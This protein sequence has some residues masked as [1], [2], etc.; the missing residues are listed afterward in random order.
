MATKPFLSCLDNSIKTERFISIPLSSEDISKYNNNRVYFNKHDTKFAFHNN[1]YARNDTM[2]FAR[3]NDNTKFIPIFCLNNNNNTKLKEIVRE[4]KLTA[5]ADMNTKN[6]TNNAS[7][8]YECNKI[9]IPTDNNNWYYTDGYKWDSEYNY[10]MPP[11]IFKKLF[12]K[13]V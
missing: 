13:Q 10:N 5:C 6:F 7:G 3:S 8:Q 12:V 2:I 9:D 4:N 11:S 1:I